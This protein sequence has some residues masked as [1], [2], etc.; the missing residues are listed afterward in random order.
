MLVLLLS[1]AMGAL[2]AI[3]HAQ[4]QV[5]S[6]FWGSVTIDGEAAPEGTEV[7]G[8]VDGVDCTQAAPGER[9]AV[10]EGDATFYVLHVVHEGQR[11]GCGREGKT[12]T[13]TINGVPAK[14]QGT[15]TFG[16]QQLDLSTG[17]G[18]V[19]PL[20]TSTP[21]LPGSSPATPLP[22]VTGTPPTP[23]TTTGTPAA[24][25]SRPPGTPSPSGTATGGGGAP[26][27]DDRDDGSSGWIPI[28]VVV[29]LITIGGAAAGIGL[30]RRRNPPA[31]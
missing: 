8:L 1:L 12:V 26:S 29:G 13:F 4:P 17:G 27:S 6:T 9:P 16:P 21:T 10:R 20:P 22:S 2:S 18:E 11:P 3:A 30:S 23:A 15:W 7:R 24:G 28:A 25:E 14:Q 5:P 19:V 31:T